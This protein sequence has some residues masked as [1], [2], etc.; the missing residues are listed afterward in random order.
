MNKQNPILILLFI[1]VS[2][3]GFAL[4][5]AHAQKQHEIK[6]RAEKE[7]QLRTKIAE[8]A[9]VQAELE[10]LGRAKAE[11]EKNLNTRIA[12]LEQEM[13]GYEE[14]GRE[15][16]LKL[17]SALREKDG[18]EQQNL[19]NENKISELTKKISRLE[20]DRQDLVDT[21]KKVEA[22]GAG[23]RAKRKEGGEAKDRTGIPDAPDVKLGRIVVQ[24]SSGNVARVEHVDKNYGFILINAGSKDGIKQ[25]A[26][27]NVV[28][29]SR[30]V[31]KAVVQKLRA[32]LS[33]ALVLPEYTRAEIEPRDLVS[34]P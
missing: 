9:A 20:A 19:A 29:D 8:L 12:S 18:L 13:A 31:G 5:S 25:G 10:D 6:L 1:I 33:A 30:L 4:F 21:L 26:V 32:T 15:L 24:K 34:L 7:T 23:P 28:R 27:L 16:A 2:L 22:A 14:S 17:D 11:N 3:L